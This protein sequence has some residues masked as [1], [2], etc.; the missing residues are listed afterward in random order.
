MVAHLFAVLG[1]HKQELAQ[2]F[3]IDLHGVEGDIVFNGLIQQQSYAAPVLGNHGHAALERI[4][5]VVKGQGRS[6][7]LHLARGGVEAHH[8]VG[9]ADFALAGQAA[10][11]EDFAF[12]HLK[13]DALDL[14]AGHVHDK[15]F[16]G[17]SDPRVRVR[18]LR[19]RFHNGFAL[20]SDHQLRQLGQG[21]LLRLA[22]SC[23]LAVAQDGDAVG[24]GHH[25]VQTVGNKNDGDTALRDLLHY[26]NELFRLGFGQ[27]GGR[28]VKYQQADALFVNF[29]GDFH[30]LH[31]AHGQAL[32]Q[33]HFVQ[34]HAH[35]VQSLARVLAHGGHIQVFQVLAVQKPA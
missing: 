2:K 33:C 20:A 22:R 32:H 3:S 5:G 28:L 15:V 27:N 31:V 14:F 26:G 35:A 17:K 19:R 4:F 13:V 10:H 16:Y 8:T 6:K 9:N 30:K 25:L 7:Q 1:G 12:A 11:A 21:S 34:A 23:Q 18:R 29:T 24:G